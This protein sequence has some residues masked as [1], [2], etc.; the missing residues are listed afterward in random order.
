MNK[1][2]SVLMSVYNSEKLLKNQS[3][4]F[5]SDLLRF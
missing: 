1:K 4:A 5:E 3:R 2:I